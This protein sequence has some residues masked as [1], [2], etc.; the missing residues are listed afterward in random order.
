MVTGI[1]A[2]QGDFA[3]HQQRLHELGAKSV[4]VRNAQMLHAVD[5]LI[6]PGGESTTLLR[7]LDDNFRKSLQEAIQGG[8]PV[9]ATCA[10]LILLSRG[11]TNPG[12]DSLALLDIDVERN[13][14]GRQID[15]FVDL[16]LNWTSAGRSELELVSQNGLANA[17]SRTME[18]VFIRAPRI[19]RT[20]DGVTVL[21]ERGLEPVLVKQGKI[22]GATFHPEL[23]ENAKAVHQLLLEQI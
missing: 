9:L 1:L 14:Y 8:I 7:L 20:G 2:L 11:V 4:L 21:V 23:S 10:G 3:L 19:T 22:L 6:M 13:S 18:G 16:N 15:S 17:A 12:Q 5:A